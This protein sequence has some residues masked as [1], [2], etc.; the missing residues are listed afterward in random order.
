MRGSVPPAADPL[1]PTR[2]VFGAA[3]GRFVVV[4]H[5]LMAPWLLDS[6]HVLMVYVPVA[7]IFWIYETLL[8]IFA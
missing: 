1:P 6:Y 2:P 3:C 8:F 7:V 5:T 4:V